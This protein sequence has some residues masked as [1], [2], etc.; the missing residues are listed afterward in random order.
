MNVKEIRKINMRALA[1]SIGGISAM[2]ECLGKSQS[3]I[4]HLIGSS[5]IKN[6]GDR[7]AGQVEVAFNKPAGWLDKEHLSIHEAMASY[8]VSR[9]PALHCTV[10]LISWQQAAKWHELAA[11]YVVDKSNGSE[12]EIPVTTNIGINAFA[13]KVQGESMESPAGISFPHNAVIVVDPDKDAVNGSYVVV[14]GINEEEAI[15][16]KQLIVDGPARYL[17]PLNPRYPILELNPGA[18]I[19]GVVRQ[20]TLF[21]D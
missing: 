21:I 1:R 18:I 11:T 8:D 7:I 10:P 13:L 14:S 2:A 20:M 17:K 6:I 5:P 12:L 3:Q 16:F 4:S 19:C 9:T 15:A